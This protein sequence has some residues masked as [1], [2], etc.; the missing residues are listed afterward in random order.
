VWQFL[1]WLKV[2]N[3]LY[4][5]ISLDKSVMDLYPKDGYLPRIEDS[6]ICDRESDAE[7]IFREETTAMSEHPAELLGSS[8]NTL[9]SELF[10]VMI[11]KMGVTDPE[12]NQMPGRLFIAA[13]LRNLVP[14][15]SELPNL[16][17]YHGSM[18]VP[19]YNN[20]NLIPGM[21]LTLF[22]MG[23]GGFEVPDR[24]C[25][26]LFQKQVEYY[27]NLTDR[28][29]HYHHLFLFVVLNIIQCCTAHL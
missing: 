1:Q 25:V 10:S 23:T 11:E 22:P 5:N 9:G 24:A 8:S 14:E 27:L 13:A 29:F 26:I 20:P 12:C 28:S 16:V 17:L 3:W 2:H 15:N 21:Y 7:E 4:A 18:A 6:V 19:E